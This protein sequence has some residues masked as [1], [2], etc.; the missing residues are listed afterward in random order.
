M[1]DGTPRSGLLTSWWSHLPQYDSRPG[2]GLDDL[3]GPGKCASATN[4]LI[5]ALGHYPRASEPQVASNLFTPR[6][7]QLREDR[8]ARSDWGRPR[9]Q[10]RVGQSFLHD[11]TSR[12]GV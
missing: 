8:V 9:R 1:K 4:E 11:Q 10:G 2:G 5:A 6:S 7:P 12:R 3:T